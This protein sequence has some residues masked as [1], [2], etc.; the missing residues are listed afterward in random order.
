MSECADVK[1]EAVQVNPPMV[2]AA[3][4]LVRRNKGR[5]QLRSV[6]P[7]GEAPRQVVEA[8]QHAVR[9]RPTREEAA[10]IQRIEQLR[11]LLTSSSAT[12][13]IDDFGAGPR[14][15]YDRGEVAT[16][17]RVSR[18][19]GTMT[20]SSKPPRWAYLLFRLVRSLKP[21]N[22]VELGSCVGISACYQAA[23]LELNGRGRLVTLEGAD[24]LAARS[25]RSLEELDL[26]HRAEVRL[27][28][29]TDTLPNVISEY[30]PVDIAFIDGHHVEQATLDYGEQIAASAAAEALI[31]FDDIH[32]SAGMERA[33]HTVVQDHR[34]ALTVETRQLG[35]AVLSRTATDRQHLSISYA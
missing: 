12:L 2:R 31:V 17:H 32:W 8:L 26:T 27:G 34:Y 5:L 9:G 25:K 20:Q 1:V 3:A 18:T 30:A 11:N 24:V 28:R 21:E 6:T 14:S 33:W 7:S 10:W 35:L 13:E 23:A 22:V 4:H 19:L 29:F 16:A 15:T